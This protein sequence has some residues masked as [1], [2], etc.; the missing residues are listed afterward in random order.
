MCTL[1]L[2]PL[3][4]IAQTD[5]STY[6]NIVSI[7]AKQLQDKTTI[8][9][10]DNAE[11]A[12]VLSE[13]SNYQSQVTSLTG[14]INNS[15]SDAIAWRQAIQQASSTLQ[16]DQSNLSNLQSSLATASDGV[17]ALQEE[18]MLIE[19]EIQD[20][21]DA[22]LELQIELA[23]AAA[24]AAYNPAAYYSEVAEIEPLLAALEADNSI[25]QSE[26]GRVQSEYGSLLGQIS[27]LENN[28][29]AVQR[30]IG[31]DQSSLQ[32]AQDYYAA[33]L[34]VLGQEQQQLSFYQQLLYEATQD[35]GALN[36]EI[37]NC[38]EIIAAQ[39]AWL[40]ANSSYNSWLANGAPLH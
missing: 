21:N 23:I 28:I 4:V 30:Q 38:N 1:L 22:I 31:L 13:I 9:G 12:N 15:N 5:Q 3:R 24:F 16:T 11:K 17:G 34:T 8:L 10:Y 19:S 40:T 33:T 27:Q 39:T 7:K 37:E 14:L 29:S 25:L 36:L 32:S 18:A 20:N 26:L 2:M 6:Q 35:L